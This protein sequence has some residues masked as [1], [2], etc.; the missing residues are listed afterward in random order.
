MYQTSRNTDIPVCAYMC[1]EN[2]IMNIESHKNWRATQIAKLFL[3]K[4]GN[5][6]IFE[7]TSND[8]SAYDFM[9]TLKGNDKV[10]FGVEVKSTQNPLSTFKKYVQKLEVKKKN[11][12][13]IP[14]LIMLINTKTE[15]GK[16]DFLMMPNG[17]SDVHVNKSVSLKPIDKVSFN[18][19]KSAIIDWYK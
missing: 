8:E 2:F 17:R 1:H 4:E 19:L 14:A 7:N 16:M 13:R 12:S 5:L 6:N 15:R 9:V 18:D 3:L 11:R 10:Q